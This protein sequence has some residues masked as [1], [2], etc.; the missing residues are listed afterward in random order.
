M[1]WGA[2]LN[3]SDLAGWWYDEADMGTRTWAWAFSIVAVIAVVF[4]LAPQIQNDAPTMSPAT[5]DDLIELY[6]PNPG[7]VITSPLTVTGRARGNW[8]FEGGFPL[9]LVD[10]DGRIIAES[11]ATA[12][13]KMTADYVPF[14]G[15]ITFEKPAYGARGALI[16]K[17]DNPS[18][19]PEHD[20]ALEIPVFFSTEGRSSSGGE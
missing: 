18:G 13:S 11:R 20:N 15:T 2:V 16:L 10:W 6:L 5:K 8:F 14:R 12:E 17:K 7:A 4:A 19:L 1:A 3:G 9:I